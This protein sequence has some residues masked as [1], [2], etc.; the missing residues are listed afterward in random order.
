MMTKSKCNH[1]YH[2]DAHPGLCIFEDTLDIYLDVDKNLTKDAIELRN[3][4]IAGVFLMMFKI[5]TWVKCHKEKFK[6]DLK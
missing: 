4:L 1:C 3:L 2:D 6:P 5:E